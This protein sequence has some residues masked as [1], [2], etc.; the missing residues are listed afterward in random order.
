MQTAFKMVVI[1]GPNFVGED[2]FDRDLSRI[3]HW[4]LE[5]LCMAGPIHGDFTWNVQKASDL[6]DKLKPMCDECI[7]IEMPDNY[8][9]FPETM[10]YNNP[11]WQ[12]LKPELQDEQTFPFMTKTVDA[13]VEFT[14]RRWST[15]DRLGYKNIG[16][17]SMA[18]RFGGRL[19]AA[20]GVVHGG[21]PEY[22]R[23]FE[24]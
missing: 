22:E 11:D 18:T 12:N 9:N 16:K 7:L 14:N 4:L 3:G 5:A 23:T 6:I 15:L 13:V 17:L 20:V 8:G 19:F 1:A 24:D 21:A 10:G 2:Q